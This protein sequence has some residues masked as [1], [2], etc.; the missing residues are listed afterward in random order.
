L[1]PAVSVTL[2]SK[3]IWSWAKNVVHDMRLSSGMKRITALGVVSLFGVAIA[4]A[5]RDAM[6]SHDGEVVLRFEVERVDAIDEGRR[7][8]AVRMVVVRRHAHVRAAGER[9]APAAEEVRAGELHLGRR[10]AIHARL[11]RIALECEG[12]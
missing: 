11:V 10:V 5:V 9:A 1:A 3:A 8:L 2:P 12:A 7:I 4:G 6:A